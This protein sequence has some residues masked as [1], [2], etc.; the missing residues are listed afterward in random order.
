MLHANFSDTKIV[1]LAW[2][3]AAEN[4]YNLPAAIL[5]I[6]SDRLSDAA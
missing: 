3:N 5:G 2:L 1:E 6:G 4:Y